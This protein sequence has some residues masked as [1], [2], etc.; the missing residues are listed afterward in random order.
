MSFGFIY[1]IKT[2]ISVFYT[3]FFR[4][5]ID[6]LDFSVDTGP[7]HQVKPA[8]HSHQSYP[9]LCFVQSVCYIIDYLLCLVDCHIICSTHNDRHIISTQFFLTNALVQYIFCSTTRSNRTNCF[10]NLLFLIQNPSHVSPM[11]IRTQHFL[12]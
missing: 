8:G 12:T 3:Y 2:N 9:T 11:T 5:F 7:L 6:F 4:V 10:I 1:F